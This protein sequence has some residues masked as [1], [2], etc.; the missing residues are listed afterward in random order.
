MN[1]RRPASL[2]TRDLVHR[3]MLRSTAAMIQA[4]WPGRYE[5]DLAIRLE[6]L[7]DRVMQ[8]SG[9]TP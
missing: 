6:A 1:N 5:G 8:E 4:R 2:S 9:E 7:A 3:D